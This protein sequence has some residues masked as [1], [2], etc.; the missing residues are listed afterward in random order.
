MSIHRTTAPVTTAFA[1]D[2]RDGLAKPQK[3]LLS[4]YLYDDIGSELF[5]V[6]TLLPEYG[7]SRAGGRLLEAHSEEIVAHV[8]GPVV[9]AELGSG[10]SKKT[11]WILEA[12]SHR[13]STRYYPIDISAAALARS[14]WELREI[15]FVSLVGFEDDY[16]DGLGQVVRRRLPGD[17]LLVLFLGSTI[18]NFDRAAGVSFLRDV[19]RQMLPGDSLL[20]ATDLEKPVPQIETAYNDSLGVTAAFN[21]N[22]LARINRELDGNF[23]LSLFEHLASYSRLERRI[24]MHLRA[25]VAHT[26]RIPGSDIEVSFEAGETIWTESS[27]KFDVDEVRRMAGPAGFRHEAVWVDREWPFAQNLWIAV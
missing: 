20:L 23:D 13:Q 19:R 6:I 18:G 10:S 16:L 27:H 26:V 25:R 3:E 12:L 11:R 17:H 24:E 7:L 4:K 9:V 2:V 15:P 22:V 5:E 1:Q 8:P 14:E 21:L